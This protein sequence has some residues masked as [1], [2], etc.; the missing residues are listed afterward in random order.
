MGHDVR[1]STPRQELPG[2]HAAPGQEIEVAHG[3]HGA[4]PALPPIQATDTGV[5]ATGLKVFGGVV[6][7]G[8]LASMFFY[9]LTRRPSDP[10]ALWV[11]G[12]VTVVV[13]AAVLAGTARWGR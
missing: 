11:I 6:S 10:V 13:A 2:G 1:V 3:G 7:V 9:E 12:L 8:A 4:H 5:V